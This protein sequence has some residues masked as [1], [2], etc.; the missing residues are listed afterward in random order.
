MSIC[1][2]IIITVSCLLSVPKKDDVVD[3]ASDFFLE[4][5]PQ[6]G[7]DGPHDQLGYEYRPLV[8]GKRRSSIILII[9]V[10]VVFA[11]S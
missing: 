7:F 9:L 1:V 8:L 5:S 6:I 4:V 2:A 10:V 11:S 3:D